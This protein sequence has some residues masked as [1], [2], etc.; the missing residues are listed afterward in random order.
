LKPTLSTVAKRSGVSPATV[1]FVL[2]NSRQPVS[3]SEETKERVRAAALELG[4]RPSGIARALRTGRSR[5]LGVLGTNPQTFSN[6]RASGFT[7]ELISGLL[8]VGVQTGYHLTFLTGLYSKP[9][10]IG[11]VSDA[12][13]TDGLLVLNRDLENSSD[14]EALK[15]FSKPVVYALEYPEDPEAFW[16]APDDVQGG[17]LATQKLLAAGH[18]KIGFVKRDIFPGIFGRRQA[19]YEKAL[20][21]ASAELD[22]EWILNDSLPTRDD[23]LKKGITAFVCANEPIA[24][25]FKK[26]LEQIGFKIPQDISI[27]CFSHNVPEEQRESSL[28]TVQYSPSEV[29]AAAVTMLAERIEKRDP[30]QAQQLF[31]Y[32]FQ[33]GKS[34]AS[35][36]KTNH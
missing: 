21:D 8:S 29:V 23:F 31:K 12:E 33:E 13:I 35:L 11:Y 30:E 5:M 16:C 14:E 6:I 4:Y 17:M 34:L 36:N 18:K 19:G 24:V 22:A 32:T 3:I 20:K 7:H 26:H 25:Q 9:G 1:S 27:V 28:A 10:E 2:N 15:F